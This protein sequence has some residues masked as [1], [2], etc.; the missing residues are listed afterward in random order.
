MVFDQKNT[1]SLNPTK[2]GEI[3][4]IIPNGSTI[5]PYYPIFATIFDGKNKIWYKEHNLLISI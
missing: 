2:F 4:I 3:E 1:N 5:S